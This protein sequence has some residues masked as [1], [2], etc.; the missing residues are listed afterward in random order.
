MNTTLRKK[1]KKIRTGQKH[2]GG[3]GDHPQDR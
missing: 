2:G 3:G 1:R